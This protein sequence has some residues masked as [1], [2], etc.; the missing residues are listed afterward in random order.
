MDKLKE[1]KAIAK[2]KD[3]IESCETYKQIETASNLIKQ[4]KKI[5]KNSIYYDIL[6]QELHKKFIEII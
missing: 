4:F 6:L 1:L 2:I 3:V 5:F